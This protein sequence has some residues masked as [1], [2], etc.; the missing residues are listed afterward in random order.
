MKSVAITAS[1][2]YSSDTIEMALE[3]LKISGGYGKGQ[4]LFDVS[5][6]V[7]SR[8]IVVLLG[9]NGAGKTTLMN[10]MAGLVKPWSGAVRRDEDDITGFSTNALSDMGIGYVPQNRPIF[11]SL[12]VLENLQ[13]GCYRLPRDKVASAIE[14]VLEAFPRLKER[15]GNA[16]GTLSGGERKMVAIARALLGEPKYLLLDEP[17]EGVWPAV[18]QEI[19]RRLEDV[20]RT[21]GVLL[22]E[23]HLR[24]ALDL[25]SEGFVLDRG[26]IVMS[27]PTRTLRD[28]PRL[29][30]FLTP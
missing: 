9:R 6:A 11:T 10:A 24:F 23:Q 15:L 8:G 14:R 13:V 26:Q 22:V 5:L 28:D 20:A 1:K 19:G 12:T 21:A 27:G 4:V 25:G 3:A 18:I 17:T 30:A 2:L 29:H 16:A 7:P